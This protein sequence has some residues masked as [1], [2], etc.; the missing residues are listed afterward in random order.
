MVLAPLV[1][2]LGILLTFLVAFAL[3][4]LATQLVKA[5]FQVADSALGWI[6]WLGSKITGD[7]HRIEQRVTHSLGSTAAALESRIG[8]VYHTAAGLVRTMGTKLADAFEL[9]LAL[10][11]LLAT[12]ASWKSVLALYHSLVGQDKA[13][14]SKVKEHTK[15][16]HTTTTVVKV[17]QA[18]ANTATVKAQA[19]SADVVLPRDIAGLR[20]QVRAAEDSIARLWDRV[21]GITIPSAKTLG[22]AAVAIALGRLGLG[23]LRCN[24]VGKVSKRLCGMDAGLLDALLAGSTLVLGSISIVELAKA[25]QEITPTIEDG[26]RF[27]IRELG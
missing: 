6:P 10:T 22:V 8:T 24:N 18:Q 25:C 23:S 26:A 14:V 2:D 3:C 4:L 16:I 1:I 7:L 20:G 11:A 21:R 27:F 5:L 17:V 19:I 12:L 15:T 9:L 13:T